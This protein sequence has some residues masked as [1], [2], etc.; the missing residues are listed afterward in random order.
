MDFN[1]YNKWLR[2]YATLFDLNADIFNYEYF[3]DVKK[4]SNDSIIV[5]FDKLCDE[6][7]KKLLTNNK[8]F[9]NI[10]FEKTDGKCYIGYV[11]KYKFDN[12]AAN[13]ITADCILNH[14]NMLITEDFYIKICIH[15]KKYLDNSFLELLGDNYS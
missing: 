7:I 5:L 6:Y 9:Y 12:F 14:T 11:F 1:K 3:Y 13:N 15:W 2:F 10:V 8:Y 4:F